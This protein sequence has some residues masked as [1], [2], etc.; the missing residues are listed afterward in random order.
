VKALEKGDSMPSASLD[1]AAEI[2][3]LVPVVGGGVRYGSS[4]LGAPAEYIGDIG[5]KLAPNYVGPTRSAAEPVAKGLGIPG[6]AQ[7]VKSVRI[8]NRGGSPVDAVLGR[9]PKEKATLVNPKTL[10]GLR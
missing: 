2:A 4:M 9:Y 10:K 7:L 8:T 5:K 3:S 6:T 1:A